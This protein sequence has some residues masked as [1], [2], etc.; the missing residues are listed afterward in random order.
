MPWTLRKALV[1]ELCCGQV[2]CG[3]A[4]GLSQSCRVTPFGS[5]SYGVELESG[6]CSFSLANR[7]PER[8][9]PIALLTPNPKSKLENEWRIRRR[10]T[11]REGRISGWA[12]IEAVLVRCSPDRAHRCTMEVVAEIDKEEQGMPGR[13]ATWG[14]HLLPP[15]AH[16]SVQPPKRWQPHYILRLPVFCGMQG[17]SSSCS[18]AC[19]LEERPTPPGLSNATCA[20]MV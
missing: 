1:R 18:S 6:A 5:A 14:R 15:A 13:V 10:A 17:K 20:G 11:C 2:H 4:T 8:A 19:L 16:L 12:T 7:E 3:L 9:R